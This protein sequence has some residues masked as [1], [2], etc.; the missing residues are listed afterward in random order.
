MPSLRLQDRGLPARAPAM[1]AVAVA[2]P[3]YDYAVAAETAW[4]DAQVAAFEIDDVRSELDAV[5]LRLG[6]ATEW[7][8]SHGR[9]DA[10]Y[11][12]AYARRAEIEQEERWLR[13]QRWSRMQRCWTGCKDCFLALRLVEDRAGWL[14]KF[15]PEVTDA[16]SPLGFWTALRGGKRPS[17]EWPPAR[18]EEFVRAGRIGKRA[19]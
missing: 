5:L 14:A 13:I 19:A 3:G 15:A 7:F 17:G 16:S 18:G 11:L 4:L 10:L 12:R 1:A 6:R 9:D 2:M 8:E